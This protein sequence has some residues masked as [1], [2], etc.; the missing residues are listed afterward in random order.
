MKYQFTYARTDKTLA[1][2]TDEMLLQIERMSLADAEDK[3]AKWRITAVLADDFGI[4]GTVD[5]E[6]KSTL[7]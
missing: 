7:W 3:C 1:D 5:A 6:G 2:V 4:C